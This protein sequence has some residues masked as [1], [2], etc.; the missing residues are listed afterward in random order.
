MPEGD[1]V[2]RTARRLHDALAGQELTHWDV[3]WARWATTDLK[4]ASTLEVV[5]RGKHLLH[6]LDSGHTLHTHLRMEGSWRV[7]STDKRVSL[8]RHDLRVVLGTADHWALGIRLGM[9]DVLW[10]KDEDRLVGHVGPDPLGRPV[11]ESWQPEVAVAHLTAR[12]E[13]HVGAALLDQRV[14]AGVGTMWATEALF[15]E[16]VHPHRPVGEL[17]DEEVSSLV[18]RCASLLQGAVAS[19]RGLTTYLF[20]KRGRPCPRCGTPIRTVRVADPPRDRQL[21]LCPRCQPAP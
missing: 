8:Q 2:W 12:A 4:G 6:R 15:L 17:S 21:H 9:V 5:S 1:A 18:D 19:R 13:E 7:L 3:R 11:G 20:D 16:K 14:L 10:T